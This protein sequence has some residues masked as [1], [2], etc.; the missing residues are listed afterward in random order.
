MYHEEAGNSHTDTH[1]CTIIII[2]MEVSRID[3]DVSDAVHEIAAQSWTHRCGHT[4][5]M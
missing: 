3:E 4:V 5:G 1:T 2:I